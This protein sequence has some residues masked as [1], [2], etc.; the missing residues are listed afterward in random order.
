MNKK[1]LLVL[2]PVLPNP[3]DIVRI[4][5]S[6]AFLTQYY[7]LTY[8]DPLEVVEQDPKIFFKIHQD[9]LLSIINNYDAVLEFSPNIFK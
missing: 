2:C 7:E 1:K 5:S 6:L 8:N 3:M 4:Q 9:K